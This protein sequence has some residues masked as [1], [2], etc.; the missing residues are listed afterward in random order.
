MEYVLV[1]VSRGI[2]DE[3]V[4]YDEQRM[5]IHG[6]SEYVKAM[7]PE[8]H[9]AAVFGENGMIVNAKAFLELT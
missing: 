3:V 5:A 9:D 2:V 6:L 7:S 8:H 4:F 1:T